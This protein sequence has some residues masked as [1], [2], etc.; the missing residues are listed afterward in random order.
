MSLG[1]PIGTLIGMLITDR[2]ER[3]WGVV[4]T[5]LLAIALGFA[6]ANAASGVEIM[7]TGLAMVITLYIFGTLGLIGYV[8]ELFETAIRMR[9]IGLCATIG[10]AFIFLL[11]LGIVFLFERFGQGGVVALIG[12]ILAVQALVVAVFGV[13]TRGRALEAV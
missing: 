7:I 6:Y 2:V 4:V 5:S 8:P 11:P 3:K 13:R 10:R 12:L 1:A 9:A